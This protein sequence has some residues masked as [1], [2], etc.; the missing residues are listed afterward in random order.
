MARFTDRHVD[1][2]PPVDE[3]PSP[4]VVPAPP[5]S[6]TPEETPPPTEMPSPSTVPSISALGSTFIDTA[7]APVSSL[8]QTPV[9]Q[10]GQGPASINQN[11]SDLT[12]VHNSLLAQ[13]NAGQF[14]GAALGHVQAILSDINAAISTANATANGAGAFG[15]V[16]AAE[17]AL[18]ASDLDVINTV[19]AVK[20]D[21][22]L[23]ALAATAPAAAPETLPEETTAANAPH[24][25][26][27][28]IGVIFNDAASEILGGVT[29]ANRQQITDD[30]NAVITDMEALMDANPQ[31]FDGL[32]GVHADA[33]VR[34]LQL[35]LTYINDPGISPDAAHASVDNIL[36][37][38]NII[39]GDANLADMATQGG[40]SGFSPFPDAENATPKFLDN[41][42]QTVFVANFIA[43]SNS[44]GQQ[45][46]DLVGSGDTQAIAALIGDLKAFE[47]L[48]PTPVRFAR[49]QRVAGRDRRARRRDC[50]DHQG[51]AERRRDPGY[52]GCGPDA[53]QR[54]RCRRPQCP[55]HRRHLQHRR[56][57]GRRSTGGAGGRN[58]GRPGG[59]P[60]P[61]KRRG[62]HP[63]R[64]AGSGCD[65]RPRRACWRGPRPFARARTGASSISHVGIAARGAASGVPDAPG[66]P[67]ADD[68]ERAR[69]PVRLTRRAHKGI[70]SAW[71]RQRTI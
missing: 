26:L 64:R 52:G 57:D 33:V 60:G 16:A 48:S 62:P 61:A 39:Q 20:T 66:T 21:A 30:I 9:E 67:E 4:P 46:L 38:I 43:Q 19:N 27:A 25:N 65:R 24:A 70:S 5:S 17:Q 22:A 55:G 56:R 58:A 15:S 3:A 31:M 71:P 23:S 53:R 14:S 8:G 54:G 36:D 69:S 63:Q 2:D 49:Q 10:G 7:P 34:Q 45:A 13:V 68:I 59:G 40:I 32:T 35:E 29:D 18:R 37:I 28:E 1:L 41:D 12:T 11:A 44:L 51:T 50:R 6:T 42:A 47:K